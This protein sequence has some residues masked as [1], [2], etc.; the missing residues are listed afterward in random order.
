MTRG[1]QVQA[2]RFAA[3]GLLATAVHVTIATGFIRYVL[4]EPILANGLAFITATIFSYLA[5]TLWS[6]SNPLTGANFVRFSL[7]SLVGLALTTLIS[8]TAEHYR[9]HYIYGI[10]LVVCLVPPTTFVLHKFWTYRKPVTQLAS[11]E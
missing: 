4:P 5:N 1:V 11:L 9:L 7:V 10:G 3:S 8:G 6:F 2:R